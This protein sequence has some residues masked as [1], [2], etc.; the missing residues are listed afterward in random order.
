MIYN[1][2][3][4]RKSRKMQIVMRKMIFLFL[5]FE[6][7]FTANFIVRTLKIVKKTDVVGNFPMCSTNICLFT[8][9]NEKI[10]DGA[11]QKYPLKTFVI[12]SGCTL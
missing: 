12:S 3:K 9:K 6:T 11:A 8:L 4:A 1:G 7:F 5:F 2:Q 10:R